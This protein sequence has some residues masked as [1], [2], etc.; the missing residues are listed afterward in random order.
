MRESA[1]WPE[2]PAAGVLVFKRFG[3]GGGV[4]K[5]KNEKCSS[6]SSES[7]RIHEVRTPQEN[8]CRVKRM[9]SL[10]RCR[11]V[12]GSD[13]KLSDKDLATL[14][15]QL[16]RLASLVLELRDHQKKSVLERADVGLIDRDALEERAANN[17]I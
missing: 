17:R 7:Y 2:D 3:S 5:N 16:Y 10:E 8:R 4:K 12:L 11:K 14:R 6:L 13:N 15:D 9:L 1:V